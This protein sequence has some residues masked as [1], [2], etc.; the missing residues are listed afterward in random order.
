MTRSPTMPSLLDDLR[1]A[2][3]ARQKATRPDAE[4]GESDA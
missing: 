4:K 3:E 2:V 1:A